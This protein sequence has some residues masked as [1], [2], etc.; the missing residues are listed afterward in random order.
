[1]ELRIK[2]IRPG[3]FSVHSETGTPITNAE[4][5]ETRYQGDDVLTHVVIRTKVSQLGKFTRNSGKQV[6]EEPHGSDSSPA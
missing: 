6:K 5:R 1:M 4:H 3:E 2:R